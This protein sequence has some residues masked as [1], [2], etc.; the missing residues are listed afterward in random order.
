MKVN[1]NKSNG[2]I[3]LKIREYNS[4]KKR[5][6]KKQI[7]YSN[8]NDYDKLNVIVNNIIKI[9]QKKE[10]VINHKLIIILNH[11]KI[12]EI[13]IYS[14]E[15]WNFY[16]NYN[17]IFECIE[18]NTLKLDYIIIDQINQDDL[19]KECRKNQKLVI[20][21]I[22][23]N[24][25]LNFFLNTL[26]K[27]FEDNEEFSQRFK[28]FLISELFNT[29]PV[30]NQINKDNDK[31]F[32][33]YENINNISSSQTFLI[34]YNDTNK[35]SEKII[36]NYY[37]HKAEFIQIMEEQF[38]NYSK[39]QNCFDGI[40]NLFKESDD[41]MNEDKNKN[42]YINKTNSNL[43][44]KKDDSLG[45]IPLFEDSFDNSI[46]TNNNPLFTQFNLNYSK[47]YVMEMMNNEKM[48]KKINA[49]EYYNGIEILK[50]ELNREFYEVINKK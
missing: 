39:C 37:I 25:P 26:L 8:L 14:K 41:E 31:N 6:T 18:N 27:F 29:Q 47:Q 1:S 13:Y 15:Q 5:L 40:K 20:K 34:E 28:I 49:K 45:K 10:E 46:E 9:R 50:D 12:N 16:L 43:S 44:I 3:N 2:N 48:F 38:K 35:I 30:N 21:Y 36:K 22:I 11:P 42:K 19:Y 4:I 24:I 23:R 7:E 17:L 32:E 33:D